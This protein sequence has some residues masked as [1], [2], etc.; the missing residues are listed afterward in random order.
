MTRDL[1]LDAYRYITRNYK[2]NA[3]QD[4]KMR[5]KHGAAW[6][7]AVIAAYYTVTNHGHEWCIARILSRIEDQAGR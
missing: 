2:D 6:T 3:A 7:S 5:R 4:R 1:A